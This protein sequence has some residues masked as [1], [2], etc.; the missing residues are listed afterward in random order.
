[1]PAPQR[2]RSD[3]LKRKNERRLA[4]LVELT[5]EVFP[6]A[7]WS[8]ALRQRFVPDSPSRA[9]EAYWLAHPLRA[10]RLARTLAARLGTPPGWRWRLAGDDGESLPRTFRTPPL[11]Y[12]EA[13]FAAGGGRCCVC[14]GP[15]FRFGWHRDIW[16]D[17]RANRR[18]T[19]H[20]PCV[21]A[22]KFWNAPWQHG[23]LLKRLQRHRCAATNRRLLRDA[24]VDHRIPL[25]RVWREARETPWPHLLAYWGSPNLQVI[26]GGAHRL[27]C[28]AEARERATL[29]GLGPR[30]CYRHDVTR[31]SPH[32]IPDRWEWA[33]LNL[34]RTP[35]LPSCFANLRSRDAECE[36]L[37]A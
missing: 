6:P 24:E 22:W 26:N 10:E 8:H 14:G 29:R 12:R 34:E 11:P 15:V 2:D 33:W 25:F 19:W 1:M 36:L 23:P 17:G 27:K 30:R 37:I 3:W 13:A 32:T 28:A 4:R 16:Q 35:T 5:P 9:V 20:A 31:R 7:V 21:A 18:A